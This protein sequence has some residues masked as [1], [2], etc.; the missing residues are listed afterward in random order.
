MADGLKRFYESVSVRKE[1]K[2]FAILLDARELRTPAGNPLK[3]PS[4]ALAEAVA[5]EW[6]TQQDRIRPD[7]M[8]LTRLVNTAVERTAAMPLEVI[9]KL[10]AYGETDLLCHWAEYPDELILRQ[11]TDWQPL[12]DWAEQ[13]LGVRLEPVA[14]IRPHPQA[15][16]SLDTLRRHLTAL[17]PISLTAAETAASVT[18]SVIL[19]LA[20]AFGRLTASDAWRI[21]RIDEDYQI[22]KWG[23]D[24]EAQRLAEGR[25]AALDVA[26]TVFT[27][28]HPEPGTGTRTDS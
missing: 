28:L 16:E 18:G 9:D 1:G 7:R 15:P 25:R 8:P 26:A 23:E 5:R 22:E 10:A 4:R 21:S 3:L 24:A 13:S 11:R 27:A 2:S 12:L 19:A 14:G 17:D 6:A 20:L